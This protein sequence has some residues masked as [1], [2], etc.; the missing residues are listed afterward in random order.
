MIDGGISLLRP[1]S[2]RTV[3]EVIASLTP[4]QRKVYDNLIAENRPCGETRC[5][6]AQRLGMT[7]NC[8]TVLLAKVRRKLTLK[9]RRGRPPVT[10]LDRERWDRLARDMVRRQV[11]AGQRCPRCHLLLPCDHVQ[12]RAA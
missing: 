3:D 4:Y 9:A 5:E 7:V 6:I 2:A 1:K 8:M 12:A 11:D 10:D